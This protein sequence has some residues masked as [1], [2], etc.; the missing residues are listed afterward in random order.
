MSDFI[1]YRMLDGEHAGSL[2]LKSLWEDA[3]ENPTDEELAT[4]GI[5]KVNI[6]PDRVGQS[7]QKF[8][9]VNGEPIAIYDPPPYWDE[10]IGA[11]GTHPLYQRANILRETNGP[12]NACMGRISSDV[13]ALNRNT[14]NL[15]WA[16]QRL[17]LALAAANAPITAGEQDD[18]DS[19]ALSAG[20]PA[21]VFKEPIDPP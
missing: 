16:F 20:F 14:G 11:I 1:F 18:I 10:L 17:R 12:I 2:A 19:I 8:K 15:N 21:D 9:I 5:K 3:P 6:P 7:I 13:F 4:A